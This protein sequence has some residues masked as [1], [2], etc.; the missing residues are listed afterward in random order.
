M[1][2]EKIYETVLDVVLEQFAV[3]RDRVTSETAFIADLGAD[4]L[5][6][7][8]LIME[9]EDELDV[10]ISDDEAEKVITVGDAVDFLYARLA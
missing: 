9:F 3:D 2:R 10:N 1:T 6:C 8:E 5:D 7:V 4:S